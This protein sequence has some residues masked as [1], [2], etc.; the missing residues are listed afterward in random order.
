MVCPRRGE[1]S[2]RAR[3][4]M[5]R[6]VTR[7]RAGSVSQRVKGGAIVP[8]IRSSTEN[9]LYL[10]L[11]RILLSFLL[12]SNNT[13]Y[14]DS[15]STHIEA[16]NHSMFSSIS[17]RTI[18]TPIRKTT[19]TAR[20]P[21]LRRTSPSPIIA[22]PCPLRNNCLARTSPRAF[23]VSASKMSLPEKK[24]RPRSQSRPSHRNKRLYEC[25]LS[26]ATLPQDDHRVPRQE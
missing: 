3:N 6:D 18:A 16:R 9:A 10:K 24:V 4:G 23:S 26:D 5:N 2:D 8:V 12:Q 22:R 15:S 25:V 11:D 19:L 20:S 13:P 14:F 1:T 21:C 17:S 7:D